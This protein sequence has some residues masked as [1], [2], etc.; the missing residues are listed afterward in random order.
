[1]LR[2]SISGRQATLRGETTVKYKSMATTFALV[3]VA[4]VV[5]L[6][7]SLS[8]GTTSVSASSAR[9]GELHVTKECSAYTGA[10][11]AYCTITG[12]NLADIEVGSQV[13]YSQAAVDPTTPE[14]RSIGL[15]SSAVLYVGPGDWAVGRC[16]LDMTGNSGLCTF[17]DGTGRLT[18]LRARV[19]VSSTDGVNY[20]WNGTYSFSPVPEREN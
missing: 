16:T 19:V 10:A 3:L 18:G 20:S 12:S 11:G 1:M 14:G 2:N 9:R 15:D 5:T 6:T 7:L 8:Q 13:L 17:S 4:G